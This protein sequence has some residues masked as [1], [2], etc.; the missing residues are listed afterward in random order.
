MAGNNSGGKRD[1]GNDLG[2]WIAA[3]ILLMTPLW[4]V[5]LIMLLFK[6]FGGGRSR[7]SRHP[8]DIRREGAAAPG[9][10]GMSGGG[11]TTPS[12]GGLRPAGNKLLDPNR[13]RG[14]T[15]G[16][17]ALAVI[18]GV[19]LAAA[20]PALAVGWG[21]LRAMALLSPAIGLLI[22]GLAM[23][24]T[25]VQRT[26]KARRFRKYLVLIGRRES[27]A[28]AALAQAMPASVRQAC[29]DLQEMLDEGCLPAG[30][31]DMGSGRLIL[32]DEGLREEPEPEPQPEEPAAPSSEDEILNEIRR[33]ND[34]IADEEMSRKIDCIGE[35]T[36]K[37]FAYQKQN[38]GKAGQMRSF[39][40][41]YLPT[42]LKI[43]RAYAQMEAQGVEGE[44]IRAA[45]QRIEGMMDKVVEGFEKQLDKLFE[46]DAM[47]VAADVEVL[48]RMLQKDG[49]SGGQGMTMGG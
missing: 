11:R 20:F 46:N 33:V 30:Y 43:L 4:F 12:A 10:Q 13:G 40:S 16:G 23:A 38:P 14:L 31:L 2:Y 47:D 29:G 37:I 28:I 42:T 21:A 5:G 41:Y 35:I 49:L 24:W 7:Q 17:G 1:G 9:T 15:I 8:Y 19:V 3:I 36:G 25:G 48:E 34:E 18:F 45:K 27:V 39:L 32:S 26:K 44:N 6:L 22:C